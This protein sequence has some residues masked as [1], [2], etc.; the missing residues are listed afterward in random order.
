M[1]N[2]LP[3]Y[4]IFVA[5]N[6]ISEPSTILEGLKPCASTLVVSNASLNTLFY[7]AK[8]TQIRLTILDALRNAFKT[9]VL[10]FRQQ[11]IIVNGGKSSL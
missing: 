1:A 8:M 11:Y 10:E 4:C 2:H 6:V 9:K 3:E 7:C 5:G